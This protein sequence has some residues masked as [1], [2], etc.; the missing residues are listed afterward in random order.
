MHSA[1]SG[2]RS[3]LDGTT[4]TGETS[5]MRNYGQFCPIARASEILAERWTPII[6]NL[7]M[8]CRTFNEI[9]AGAPGAVTGPADPAPA[10]TGTGRGARDPPQAGRRR[11]AVRADPG[12][13]GPV[14][15]ADRPRRLGRGVDTGHVRARRPRGR[16]L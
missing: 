10:R 2:S 5:S 16:P 15:G 6:R 8:G 14:A 7:L 1:C 11:V 13:P 12:R 9:A 3:E 4:P